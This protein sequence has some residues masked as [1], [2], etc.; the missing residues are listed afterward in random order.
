MN[1]VHRSF[2]ST[3]ALLSLLLFSNPAAAGM[4][5]TPRADRESGEARKAALKRV[6]ERLPQSVDRLQDLPTAELL[7]LANTP[8]SALRAASDAAVALLVIGII[9]LFVSVV[10]VIVIISRVQKHR[11][12]IGEKGSGEGDRAAAESP[13]R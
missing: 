5:A 1:S 3:L 10:I 6:A 13:A 7:V 4:I 9:V 11:R 8:E 12:H 2:L